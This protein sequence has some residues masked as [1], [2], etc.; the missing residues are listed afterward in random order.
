MADSEKPHDMIIDREGAHPGP[1]FNIYITVFVALCIFT[2]LSFI[3][4]W[5]EHGMGFGALL[6]MAIILVI[7]VCKAT[8]VAMYFM[9]VKFDWGRLYFLIIPVVILAIMMMVVL[10]PDT[11]VGWHHEEP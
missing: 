2:A 6:G 7:A 11:V 1:T 9:H 4:N 8:L 5:A 10:M 3:V